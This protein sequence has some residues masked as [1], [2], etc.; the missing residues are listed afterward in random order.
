MRDYWGKAGI[1][2]EDIWTPFSGA[3]PTVCYSEGKRLV[4]GRVTDRERELVGARRTN[5]SIA[6]EREGTEGQPRGA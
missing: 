4:W 6:K 3:F 1:E 5:S 2:E